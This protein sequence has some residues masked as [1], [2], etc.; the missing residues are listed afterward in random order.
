[1]NRSFSAVSVSSCVTAVL[2]ASVLQ[3]AESQTLPKVLIEGQAEPTLT[4]PSVAAASAALT[5]VP[6]GTTL[7]D[8]ETI[9]QGR[10]STLRDA[11]DFTTGVYVQSRFGSEE[12]RISIRGSGLQRITVGA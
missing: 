9:R 7:V 3:A 12:A 1:M 5:Q 8:G 4:V 11:L 10:A 6:G 2:G